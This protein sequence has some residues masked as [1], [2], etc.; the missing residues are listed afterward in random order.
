MRS[1]QHSEALDEA[2]DERPWLAA[3]DRAV[4]AEIAPDGRSLLDFFEASCAR[5]A[6]RD[7]LVL[8]N[9]RLSYAE[10]ERSVLRAS[11]V[12]AELGVERGTSVAIQLPN[13]PQTVIAYYA[14]LRLGAR[15]V[16]TNPL[17]MASEIE[18]Q[19]GDADCRVAIVADYVYAQKLRELRPKL[20]VRAYLATGIA[21]HFRAPLR[22]IAPIA[23]ARRKQPLA[24]R[25]AAEPGLHFWRDE[26]ARE[27]PAPP[28]A[29]LA[30]E[31]VAVLQYTGGTTGRAK[32]AQLT[33]ANLAINVR[34]IDAWFTAR[35]HGREVMLGC[36]PIFHVFGM[37]V[38]MNWSLHMG[39]TLVLQPDPRDI[40]SLIGALVKERVSIFPA[41]PA[42]FHAINHH[43]GIERID[44]SS[45]KVCVSGSAPLALE[46]KQRFERLTGGRILEGYG[47]SETSPV[48]HV[49]PYAGE[50]KLGHIG[51]P[52]SG[53][54]A[55]IVDAE[56]GTRVLAP[57][58]EGELV[59]QGPQVMLGYWRRPEETANALRDGWFHT[60]DLAA[61]DAQGYFRILGRKKEMI[62]VGGFKVYP[63]E[64]D[65]VLMAHPAVL[66]SA[67]VGL[68]REGEDAARG[69]LV[70]SFVVLKP[71]ASASA[72]ELQ[73]HCRALLAPYK[74]PKAIE[75]L[76]ALPKSSMMKIL[77]RE[78]VAR[79]LEARKT[80]GA[81]RPA[82]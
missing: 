73:A 47:L 7:A 9:A 30:P 62:N 3:Y 1:E 61:M 14:A 21:D 70:H 36:L 17:Y 19:W 32:A 60:G 44:L 69:E 4:P 67:T 79:A 68:P 6:Q 63:D 51:L 27:R 15:V 57:G 23:L 35:E 8:R 48:T 12:L 41:V 71:G 43:P 76:D 42:I 72:Q 74:V 31:D 66:E 55:R 18:E 5:Y 65:H 82:S 33:H 20:P 24:A 16:L 56:S 80:G 11:A 2:G 52:V 54:R 10:L 28:R 25:L 49:N 13:L 46:T 78:L 26:L 38:C 77:R 45:V 58:E 22:W 40:K 64:L 53:T 59:L 37:S 39:A 29:Q 81:P 75:F 34:Q 50:R